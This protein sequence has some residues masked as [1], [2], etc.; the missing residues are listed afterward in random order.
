[1]GLKDKRQIKDSIFHEGYVLLPSLTQ[2]THGF[3]K[4]SRKDIREVGVCMALEKCYIL[5]ATFA[6]VLPPVKTQEVWE[7]Q[8]GLITIFSEFSNFKPSK[9]AFVFHSHDKSTTF[10]KNFKELHSTQD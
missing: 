8:I 2:Y 4:L 7:S 10:K 5:A 6:L 9:Q 1:M 3:Q